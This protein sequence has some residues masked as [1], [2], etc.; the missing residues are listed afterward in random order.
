MRQGV[1]WMRLPV[2]R[3]RGSYELIALAVPWWM[4]AKQKSQ[5]ENEQ[6]KSKLRA[7][8]VLLPFHHKIH[9]CII[10][11]SKL[12]ATSKLAVRLIAGCLAF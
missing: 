2:G 6:W 1:G 3:L 7:S 10:L 9:D 12:D 8:T 4:G 5:N 11:K